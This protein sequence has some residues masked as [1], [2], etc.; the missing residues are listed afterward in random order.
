MITKKK[1]II[2][3][4]STSELHSYKKTS[5]D[6]ALRTGTPTYFEVWKSGKWCRDWNIGIH[7]K[8]V[9]IIIEEI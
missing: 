7:L 9:K 8:K 3:W 5:D 6:T 4:I 2:G 1:E